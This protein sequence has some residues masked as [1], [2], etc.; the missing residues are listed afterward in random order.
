[1]RP[2]QRFEARTDRHMWGPGER[3]VVSGTLLI[4][5]DAL[6]S[7]CRLGT[8]LMQSAVHGSA[9]LLRAVRPAA[10]RHDGPV[11][12]RAGPGRSPD[13]AGPAGRIG[14]RVLTAVSY[15]TVVY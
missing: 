6:A 2:D 9:V 13:P 15:V 10:P 4:P 3:G 12:I 5:V 1:M 7:L 11:L 8:H 14:I